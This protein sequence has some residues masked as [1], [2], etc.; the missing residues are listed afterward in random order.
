MAVS[1]PPD[2]IVFDLETL[3]F[4]R[5][6]RSRKGIDVVQARTYR[7]APGTLKSGVVS[8]VVTDEAS[9][10][11]I[12]RRIKRDAGKLD[13]ISLLLP[14][15]WFRINILEVQDLPP[16]RN[17]ADQVVRWAL[18]RSL[19]VRAEDLRIAHQTVGK[20]DGKTRILVMAALE[21]TLAALERLFQAEGIRV[22][23]IEPVG[24]NIWNAITVRE[25]PTQHDRIFIYLRNSEFTTAV[26]RGATPIFV[27]SRK[28]TSERTI[29]QEIK[30]SA[31]YL[32]GNM[33]EGKIEQCW[34][35]GDRV[36]ESV[37]RV[38]GDEFGAPVRTIALRDFAFPSP[39]VDA[40]TIEAELTACTGVF[41]A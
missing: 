28:L 18:K 16:S 37:T 26:F 31:S 17:E 12:V 8:P 21:T 20:T 39:G 2:V 24:M 7:L 25:A 22:V 5:L 14:D 10:A 29:E 32:R 9:L 3:L 40:A 13:S 36:N 35:A 27:R 30:L 38:V 41:T 6:S 11:E 15:A 33:D 34:V 19:P 23:L 4:A 1:F